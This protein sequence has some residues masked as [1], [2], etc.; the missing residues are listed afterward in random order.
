ML[1]AGSCIGHTTSRCSAPDCG[2][3]VEWMRQRQSVQTT[4]ASDS[5]SRTSTE[6]GQLC[7]GGRLGSVVSLTSQSR[8]LRQRRRGR[9][10]CGPLGV[11]GLERKQAGLILCLQEHVALSDDRRCTRR[12]AKP[13]RASERGHTR[14][15]GGTNEP[16]K[17]NRAGSFWARRTAAISVM[18]D[19]ISAGRS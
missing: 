18:R 9:K 19:N 16:H 10:R 17:A 14:C 13:G 11:R 8:K 4:S 1:R 2:I 15:S 12:M 5:S 7:A 6:T 3:F